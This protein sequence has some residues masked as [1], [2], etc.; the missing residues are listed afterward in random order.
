M[1]EDASFNQKWN[2]DYTKSRLQRC[3]IVGRQFGGSDDPSNLFLMCDKCHKESPDTNNPENFF[4]WVV[5]RRKK[6]SWIDDKVKELMQVLEIKG[7]DMETL[8]AF[9]VGN[10][11][12][13][14]KVYKE[15]LKR[16]GLHQFSISESSVYYNYADVCRE[17]MD[18]RLDS[19]EYIIDSYGI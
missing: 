17:L 14:G 6:G 15:A 1:D 12:D 3:H 11:I 18:G 8:D 9:I 13:L 4:L 19:G 5:E 16:S 7:I 10:K 2:N